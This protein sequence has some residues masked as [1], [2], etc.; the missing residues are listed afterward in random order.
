VASYG[1]APIPPDLGDII[2]PDVALDT[3][4]L[5]EATI[6]DCLLSAPGGGETSH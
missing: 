4:N 1:Y 3:L 2:V 6:Y 5:G